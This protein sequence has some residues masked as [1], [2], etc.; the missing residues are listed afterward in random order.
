M[1]KRLTEKAA[2][3][4]EEAVAVH[5]A[6]CARLR[7]AHASRENGT[8]GAELKGPLIE[9]A[10]IM[11]AAI[12]QRAGETGPYDLL[13]DDPEATAREREEAEARERTIEPAA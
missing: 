2:L 13:E 11:T 10:A 7:T 1:A 3:W 6:I 9:A 4:T 8:I 5:A 12:V